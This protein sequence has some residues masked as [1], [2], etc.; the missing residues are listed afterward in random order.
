M[1]AVFPEAGIST[2]FLRRETLTPAMMVRRWQ[3]SPLG[4]IAPRF[5]D[6]RKLLP[7]YPWAVRRMCV[8]VGTKLLLTSEAALI[9]GLR[10]PPGCVHVCYCNSPARYL[11]DLAEDYATRS[12][13]IG[14][15]GRWL[16]RQMLPRLQR[17][18]REAAAQVDHFIGNSRFIAERI[19][20]IYGREAAVI[21]PPVDVER[22]AAPEEPR[23][24]FYL[25]VSELVAYKRVDLAVEACSLLGRN[26]IVAGDGPERTRLETL[27]GP[28]VQFVGRVSDTEVVRLMRSCRAFIHPQIEDFGIAAV[29]AQA[30]GRPVIAFRGG[31][32]METVREDETGLF[33]DAQTTESLTGALER[34]ERGVEA[35]S[36]TVCRAQ[37]QHF[38]AVRFRTELERHLRQ[39]GVWPEAAEL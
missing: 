33:F 2:L 21:Y 20:R 15:P 35:I 28:T 9:K 26:L 39:W 13:G 7:F 11:W 4:L 31:G 6:H 10:K 5:V 16:F 30:A 1:A 29:E 37:A 17:F 19:R 25:V 18:D 27:A 14:G 24:D 8:P 22:F 3:V 32:A 36:P 38:G 34:F 12:A 23:G